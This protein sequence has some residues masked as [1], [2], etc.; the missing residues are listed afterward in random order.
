MAS[1]RAMHSRCC[2]PPESASALALQPILHLIPEGGLVER[3]L[4]P[5]VEVVLH[6]VQSE[7]ERHVVVD[8]LREWVRTLEHHADPAPHLDG[9]DRRAV[10][11][12]PVI[13]D[14]PVD[15]RAGDEVVH[16]IEAAKK[17]RLAAA[18]RADEGSDLV[19]ED[20]HRDVG[21][22]RRP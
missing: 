9:I 2:W 14:L 12:V 5:V 20:V 7:P 16:A 6:A 17:R 21:D 19:A 4:D 15:R 13:R 1:A 10:E 3:L 22:G 8:R 11:V 18:R